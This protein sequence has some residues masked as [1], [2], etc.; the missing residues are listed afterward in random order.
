[1]KY[2]RRHSCQRI[3]GALCTRYHSIVS[4]PHKPHASIFP[5]IVSPGT[6]L[7]VL[8]PE[9]VETL[10]IHPIP[11]IAPACHDTGSAIAAIPA[12]ENDLAWISSGTWSIAGVNVLEAMLCAKA[13]EFNLT[14]E[15]GLGGTF[16]F[17][18]NVMGLW[19]VQECRRDWAIQGE[20]LSYG[21]LAL[22]AEAADPLQT[23]LD[24]DFP[25]FLKP[26]DMPSQIAA[27][28]S[29]T[30]QQIPENKGATI[31]C[32]LESMALKYRWVIEKLEL[33]VGHP[34]VM[35]HIVVVV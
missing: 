25:E 10:K 9:V 26:G 21:E 33:L 32:I 13:L 20:E 24:P 17:S 29:R 28:A 15:G 27:F 11:V 2:P 6:R 22:L 31:R 3:R 34:I 14:N 12:E 18:K 35:I 16:S 8:S 19:L 23:I 1:V 30:R 5:E 7:G 4:P